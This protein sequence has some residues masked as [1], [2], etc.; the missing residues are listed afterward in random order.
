MAKNNIKC[1]VCKEGAVRSVEGYGNFSQ[2]TSDCKLWRGKNSICVCELCGSVQK[3]INRKWEKEISKIYDTYSIYYQS[4]GIEQAVY[5]RNSGKAFARSERVLRHVKKKMRLGKSG[6]YLDVGCGNGSALRS[7]IGLLPLWKLAGTELNDRYKKN[8]EGISGKP[9]LYTCSLKDIRGKFDLITLF[10]AL[11]HVVDPISFLNEARNK[12]TSGGVLVIDIPNYI[13]N[14][15]DLF[16]ADH[17]THFTLQTV[18]YVLL[19]AGFTTLDINTDLI[20]R[21]MVI[22]ARAAKKFEMLKA[23]NCGGKVCA[24]S[25]SCDS[26]VSAL[27]WVKKFLGKAVEVAR[28]DNFGIFGTS[29]IATW[30]MDTVGTR[31]KFFVDEDPERRGKTYMN[32]PIYHPQDIPKCGNV[33]FALPFDMAKEVRKRLY[34]TGIKLYLPPRLNYNDLF[35]EKHIFVSMWISKD[36]C[37]TA[38]LKTKMR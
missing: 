24:K 21:E 4:N 13:Q 9:R 35:L 25:S 12:L 3:A 30:L 36:Y 7:F 31:V 18:R 38:G 17:C 29:I 10:H 26:V 19:K 34:R 27:A 8:I 37:E 33:F 20:P 23:D 32:L 1:H 28:Q 5:D 6:K 2:V 11:E 15:F 16:I 22:I 14:P